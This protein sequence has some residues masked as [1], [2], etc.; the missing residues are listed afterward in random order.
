MSNLIRYFNQNR[1][2]VYLG[3]GIITFL[4]IL[5]YTIFNYITNQE[6][7]LAEQG[8]AKRANTNLS[9]NITVQSETS[10]IG[11]NMV[12]SS[13][14]E[15]DTKT[16][17]TFINH[18]NEGNIESAYNMLTEEC[19]EEMYPEIDSFVSY[20]Y[21]DIFNGSRISFELENWSNNT[22]KIDII[23]DMLSTGK[24]NNDVVK[25]DYITVD[26]KDDGKKLNINNYIGRTKLNKTEIKDNVEVTVNYKDSY[27]EY[28]VYNLTINNN[29]ETKA[30]LDKLEKLDSI[31]LEDNK[32]SK[33]LVYTN[34]IT[35]E[36]LNFNEKEQKTVELKFYNR[37][38]S[39]RIIDKLIFSEALLDYSKNSTNKFIINI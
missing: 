30:T 9:E 13:K 31:Y 16:I 15:S 23:P 26:T 5:G 19:K 1:K 4:I 29:K 20:Y 3:L 18:C 33:Y 17:E 36:M 7:N 21:G 39:D 14:L 8:Y 32:G 27:I 6:Q 12:S 10:A 28:E 11:G 38:T 24:S 34:E 22:Y 35:D 37:F 25:Q 2:E